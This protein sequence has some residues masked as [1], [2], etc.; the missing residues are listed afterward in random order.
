MYL[1]DWQTIFLNN[2]CVK[3]ADE[4]RYLLLTTTFCGYIKNIENT[5]LSVSIENKFSQ[6][7]FWEK[8]M[9]LLFNF[10]YQFSFIEVNEEK[11]IFHTIIS[12]CLK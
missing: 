2:I 8:Q 12:N 11:H 10:L 6:Q 7:L 9:I 4:I 3:A 1:I 5:F